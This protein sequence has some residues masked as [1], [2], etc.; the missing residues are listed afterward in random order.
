MAR[1]RY[2]VAELVQLVSELAKP[3]ADAWRAEGGPSWWGRVRARAAGWLRRVA[4]KI[5]PE[6]ATVTASITLAVQLPS[7]QPTPELVTVTKPATT[8]RKPAKPKPAAKPKAA[9]KPKAK[10][11]AAAARVTK[12]KPTPKAKPKAKPATTRTAKVRKRAAK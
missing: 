7:L 3:V 2:G 12:P 5:A 6:P 11:V 1:K 8:P 4:D 9:R 10:P